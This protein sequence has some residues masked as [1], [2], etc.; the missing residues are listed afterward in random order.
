MRLQV[1]CPLTSWLGEVSREPKRQGRILM[2][3][4]V[5]WWWGQGSHSSRMPVILS[6]EVISASQEQR[7][8]LKSRTVPF[9]SFFLP[10]SSSAFL[11]DNGPLVGPLAVR[12]IPRTPGNNCHRTHFCVMTSTISGRCLSKVPIIRVSQ[13]VEGSGPSLTHITHV[14]LTHF[15]LA[16]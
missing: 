8:A 5:K 12:R 1:L 6:L 16:P 10:T 3:S 9:P 2:S 7:R 15:R 14:E 13:A 11:V 4:P